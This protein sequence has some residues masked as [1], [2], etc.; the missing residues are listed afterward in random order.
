MGSL[1]ANPFVFDS[2]GRLPQVDAAFEAANKGGTIFAV[3]GR[4]SIVVLTQSDTGKNSLLNGD[5]GFRNK[6]VRLLC[7]SIACCS[8]GIMAD[9]LYFANRL[10]EEV[11]NHNY[12]YGT[13]P[14]VIRLSKS[15]AN[16]LHERTLKN[17]R[18]L[19]VKAILCGW[20]MRGKLDINEVD[21]MGNIHSCKASCIGK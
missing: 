5:G 16:I 19:G 18:P 9:S 20:D 7:K 1:G 15:A 21:P 2:D 3:K 12:A 11:A 13:D 8:S 4:D 17:Y 10:F 6:K 14:S